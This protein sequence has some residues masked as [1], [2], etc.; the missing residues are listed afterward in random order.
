MIFSKRAKDSGA[1][2]AKSGQKQYTKS[3][4]RWGCHW[5]GLAK[6]ARE[7]CKHIEVADVN[8]K[9]IGKD[10][11]EDGK[12]KIG[13]LNKKFKNMYKNNLKC[14]TCKDQEHRSM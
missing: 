7:N 14:E 1:K 8:R 11:I 2:V 9:S 13:I 10:K 4:C 3:S 12:G 5:Q 6:E